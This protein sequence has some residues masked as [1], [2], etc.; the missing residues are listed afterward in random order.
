MD[1]YTNN[2]NPHTIYHTEAGTKITAKIV[3]GSYFEKK[4]ISFKVMI[5]MF[6]PVAG[7]SGH[8]TLKKVVMQV[9]IPIHSFLDE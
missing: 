3:L 5:S 6:Q 4:N 2:H 9:I 7:R 1:F 8:Y